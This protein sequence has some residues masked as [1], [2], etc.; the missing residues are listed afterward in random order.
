MTKRLS[1]PLYLI[2]VIGSALA[3]LVSMALHTPA[4]AYLGDHPFVFVCFA[5]LVAM[6]EFRP[7]AWLSPGDGGEVTPSV[8]ASEHRLTLL[9]AWNAGWSLPCIRAIVSR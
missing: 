8:P 7:L 5:V 6:A 9:V 4:D 1:F 2:A 3:L